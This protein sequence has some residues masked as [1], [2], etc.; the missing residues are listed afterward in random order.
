MT[1]DRGLASARGLA[2]LG[3]VLAHAAASYLETPIGW[4]VRDGDRWIGVDAIGWTLHQFLMPAFFLLGGL[5][6]ARL[7]AARGARGYLR[8]RLRRI[9]LP[10]VIAIVP[11]SLAMNGLWDWGRAI[12]ARDAVAAPVPQ[13]R[14][15]S[16]PITLA[17]LWFLY[18]LLAIS[19]GAL[20]VAR[21]VN[22]R[23]AR[24]VDAITQ[25][26]VSLAIAP[27]PLWACLV[28]AGKLQLDTPLGFDLDPLVTIAFAS[29]FAW[30]WWLGSCPAALDA[31]ARAA[32]I[33]I[34]IAIGAT[35]AATPAV[36]DSRD[37][38][39]PGVIA[40]ALCALG[41]WAWVM[42]LVGGARRWSPV[43]PRMLERCARDSL[44]IYI[45]HLPLV[46]LLQIG[47]ATIDAPGVLEYVG[48]A[49]IGLGA[50][51]LLARGL[52]RV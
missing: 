34:A 40:C 25:P 42:A 4:A 29:F 16:L 10:L 46:V 6:A 47:A 36:L 20:I 35:A 50:S 31:W 15:S 19:L 21:V 3:V 30:G 12:S 2:I 18:Y 39:R 43:A 14:G 13:L 17:H 8:Q 1:E 32:P 11:V 23:G 48:I 27:L 24:W 52:R 9:A 33:L 38:A 41:A 28:A 51:A 26:L 7:L 45:A 44:W 37:G 49:A 5:A 22:A